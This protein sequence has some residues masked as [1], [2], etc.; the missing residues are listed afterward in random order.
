MVKL[1]SFQFGV[2]I[3]LLLSDGWLGNSNRSQNYTLYFKQSL[4]KSEYV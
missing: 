2:I 1:P 3:G 4:A